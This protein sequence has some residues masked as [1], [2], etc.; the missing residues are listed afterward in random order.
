[1]LPDLPN[2]FTYLVLRPLILPLALVCLCI[3]FV[4]WRFMGDVPSVLGMGFRILLSAVSPKPPV[5]ERASPPEAPLID[6]VVVGLRA[7]GGRDPTFDAAAFLAQV[8]ET[9]TKL[10]RAWVERNLDPCRAVLSDDGFEFQKAQMQRGL[11]DGWRLFAG[12]VTFADGQIVAAAANDE[13]DGITVR[14]QITCAPQAVKV[15]RGR[16]VSAWVEDW[17]FRRTLALTPPEQ[18]VRRQI[19]RRGDWKL[20]RMDHVAVHYARAA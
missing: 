11:A 8:R 9:A 12:G 5:A 18:S 14:I 2:G 1:M 10:A 4:L 13:G 7:I 16:R 20:I 6:P 3:G 19:L 15:V 17:L